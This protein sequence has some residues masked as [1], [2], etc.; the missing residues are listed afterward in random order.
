MIAAMLLS[1]LSFPA[2]WMPA[3]AQGV[4]DPAPRPAGLQAA[5]AQDAPTSVASVLNLPAKQV[6]GAVLRPANLPSRSIGFYSRGCLAGGME[7]PVD[8]PN[9]QAMRLKRN[10]NWGTPRLVAFIEKLASEVP[11][12]SS[13]PG[14]LVGDMGQPRGGPMRTGHASHQI[15]LDAD[16]W[17]TPMPNYRLSLDQRETMSAVNMV[18]T[19]WRGV[20]PAHWTGNQAAVIRLAAQDPEVERVLV[21][22]AIKRQL[23]HDAR[24]D[25]SWLR[26]VR[27]WWGHNYHMHVRL[28]C[29]SDN[30]SCRE[31]APPPPGDGCGKQLD[32]WMKLITR[33]KAPP[34]KVP[35]K[36]KPPMTVAALPDACRAVLAAPAVP[37]SQPAVTPSRTS[38]DMSQGV[39]VGAQPA[40][41]PAPT[42]QD[43]PVPPSPQ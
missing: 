30:P 27:P 39:P 8:G 41:M 33:P 24:G 13:W 31:Q 19:D 17:L 14:I 23:C 11:R 10:R 40:A 6:F 21:N 22:P 25:R 43:T 4:P 1:G 29:S 38:L 12:V 42:G 18:R 32:W 9:W 5:P 35:P 3:L 26:K 2:C 28:G 36:P 37:G 15:G 16:I 34:P 7:L 20:D